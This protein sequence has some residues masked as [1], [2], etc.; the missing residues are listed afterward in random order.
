[1]NK[2]FPRPIVNHGREKKIG[3]KGQILL[4]TTRKS[5]KTTKD[6]EKKNYDRVSLSR[7]PCMNG[8]T[9]KMFFCSHENCPKFRPQ[10][11][12]YRKEAKS[13]LCEITGNK[14]ARFERL[15]ERFFCPHGL[16]WRKKIAESGGS[17][18]KESKLKSDRKE[19]AKLD[20]LRHFCQR[21]YRKKLST[22]HWHKKYRQK[23]ILV[24]F[25]NA[26]NIRLVIVVRVHFPGLLS[27]NFRPEK[28]RALLL[29]IK[30]GVCVPWRD[31][32]EDVG[33]RKPTQLCFRWTQLAFYCFYF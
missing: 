7:L 18:E 6:L 30:S 17:G 2:D 27:H 15:D 29:L 31:N 1:M 24:P 25:S 26:W 32:K 3:Q 13:R 12:G 11:R 19:E 16:F 5:G 28:I 4:A 23:T 10:F 9:S 14:L 20:F 21:N 22:K 8:Q 33:P